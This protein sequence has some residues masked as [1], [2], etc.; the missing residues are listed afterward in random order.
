MHVYNYSG[1]AEW[2]LGVT[3]S[4]RGDVNSSFLDKSTLTS[5][6]VVAL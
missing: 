3:L 1:S 5:S 6:Q 2:F 4:S